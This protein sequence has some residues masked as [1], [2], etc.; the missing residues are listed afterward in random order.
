MCRIYM[1]LMTRLDKCN[2]TIH[3]QQ[4]NDLMQNHGIHLGFGGFSNL[5]PVSGQLLSE[6]YHRLIFQCC[7]GPDSVYQVGSAEGGE[8]LSCVRKQAGPLAATKAMGST[9]LHHSGAY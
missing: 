6:V 9:L 8:R 4:W 2:A 3:T 1:N 5:A 7:L